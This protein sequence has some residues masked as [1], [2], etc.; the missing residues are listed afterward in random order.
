MTQH[1]ID[2]LSRWIVETLK[3]V[4]PDQVEKEAARLAAEFSAYAEDAGL[5]V[6]ELE[7]DLGEDLVS[8]MADALNA[9]ADSGEVF[10]DKE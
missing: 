10:P 5:N 2:I 6:E 3:P 9:V 7:V 1:A 8:H 4:P